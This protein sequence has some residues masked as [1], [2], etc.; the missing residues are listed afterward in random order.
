[1]FTLRS[2][3]SK[4]VAPKTLLREDHLIEIL[5]SLEKRGIEHIHVLLDAPGGRA[6]PVS[7]ETDTIETGARQWRV[8]H[9][10]GYL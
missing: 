5:E 1:M 7:I 10:E 2:E 9:V 6:A 4:P 8:D 3:I